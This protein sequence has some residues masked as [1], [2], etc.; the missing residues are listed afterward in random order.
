MTCG[1]KEGE[2]HLYT[3][4]KSI[5]LKCL[6]CCGGSFKEVEMCPVA[7]CSL[8]PYRLGKSPTRKG[9]RPRGEIPPALQKFAVSRRAEIL[10][11]RDEGITL[12]DQE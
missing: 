12:K 2:I 11:N 7:D 6:D 8:Y 4:L 3:P 1:T 5:R 9:T 10:K